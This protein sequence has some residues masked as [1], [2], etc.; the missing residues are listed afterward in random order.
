MNEIWPM[1]LPDLKQMVEAYQTDIWQPRQSGLCKRHCAVVRL[2]IQRSLQTMR[3]TYT[4][5][6]HVKDDMK[7]L[8]DRFGWFWF[9]PPANAY[10]KSGISDI[11]ALKRGTFMAIET[12]FGSN[13]PTASRSAS[14]TRCARA[15]ASRSSSTRRTC[16]GSRRSWRAST[17][18][19]T[20]R[21]KGEKVPRSR[22][23]DDQCD[24][25][26]I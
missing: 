25:R 26:I 1:L 12:K 3:K 9:M 18:R 13:K 5:E 22:A 4:K 19:S 23:P 14:S 16:P 20:A 6:A 8:L 21:S 15:T 17:S 24:C 10:G 11:I 2:R 7:A